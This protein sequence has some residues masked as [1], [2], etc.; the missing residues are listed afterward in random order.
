VL[1]MWAASAVSAAVGVLVFLHSFYATF[2]WD[3]R[4]AVLWNADVDST[5][6]LWPI[7][8]HDFW[9]QNIGHAYVRRQL[10]GEE[11]EGWGVGGGGCADRATRASGP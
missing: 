7:F 1:K 8:E 5:T 4:A 6:P 2:T 9:G 3:D 10:C 11:R